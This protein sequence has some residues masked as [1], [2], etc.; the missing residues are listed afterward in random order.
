MAQIHILNGQG[1]G[2]YTAVVHAPVPVGN[3]TAGVTWKAALA[4]SGLNQTSMTVGN[5]P[6]QI[7]SAEASQVAAGDVIEAVIAWQNN[8]SWTVAERNV[9]LTDRAQR[10]ID[11][12]VA[13]LR[14][15]LAMFGATR[16]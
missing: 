14:V 12:R 4:S 15:E 8:P 13:V 5:G 6:G 9:D 16:G 3:N 1:N 2:V 10:A 7:S 11:E